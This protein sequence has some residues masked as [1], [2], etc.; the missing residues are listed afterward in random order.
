MVIVPYW[1]Y[2]CR[3]FS[4][5]LIFI[6]ILIDCI[7]LCVLF[8]VLNFHSQVLLAKLQENDVN[9]QNLNDSR[10][11]RTCG[12]SDSGVGDSFGVT[13]HG[14]R[15]SVEN[16]KFSMLFSEVNCFI[17]TKFLC[18]YLMFISLQFVDCCLQKEPKNR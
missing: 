4:F 2:F 6:S 9:L 14:R 8:P 13:R 16:K 18:K 12:A 15:E 1:F 5:N 11:S 7:F 17:H 3:G 10:L